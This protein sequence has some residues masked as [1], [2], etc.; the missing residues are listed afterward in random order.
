MS[1]KS[2]HDL[3]ADFFLALSNFL[4]PEYSSV[5]LS[6]RLL[7]GHLGCFQV[8]AVRSKVAV[9]IDVQGFVWA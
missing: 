3:T 1:S 2:F 4:L 6:I 5:Y 9:N 7:K 8:L